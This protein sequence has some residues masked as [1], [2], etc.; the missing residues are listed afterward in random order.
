MDPKAWLGRGPVSSWT[1]RPP[2]IYI[3]VRGRGQGGNCPPKFGQNSGGN[4]GKARRKKTMCKISAKS[5]PLPPL[6]EESPYALGDIDMSSEETINEVFVVRTVFYSER[7][8]SVSS[9][10]N[11]GAGV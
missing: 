7:I 10:G 3:G 9:P 5:T 11:P 2:A 1:E 6:T 4:L 8:F